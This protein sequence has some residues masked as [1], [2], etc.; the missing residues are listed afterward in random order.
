ME[1]KESSEHLIFILFAACLLLVGLWW[2]TSGRAWGQALPYSAIL[3]SVSVEPDWWATGEL[4]GGQFAYSVSSAGD[5]NGD[6]YADLLVGAPKEELDAYRGGTVHAYYGYAGGVQD[7]P[8]WVLGSE[9]QGSAFGASLGKADLNGDG[10]DEIL[11]GAP[12]F[13]TTTRNSGKVFVYGRAQ[14]NDI[15]SLI[16]ESPSPEP[17]ARYGQSISS[18]DFNNDGY[19]DLLIGAPNYRIV[20]PNDVTKFLTVGAAFV[21]YGSASGL[22]AG[23]V[24]DWT[25]IG[26]QP[27]EIL[28]SSVAGVGDVNGDG[29]DD[30]LVGAPSYNN[31]DLADAGR[32]YLFLGSDSGLGATPA[33]TY[34]GTQ[35][36]SRLGARVSPAGDVNH[37]GHADMLASVR[38]MTG[39][40]T[41]YG[42]ALAFYGSDSGLGTSPSWSFTIEQQN[43]CFGCALASAGDV[44]G[45]QID[46]IIIGDWQYNYLYDSEGQNSIEG[47][48]FIFLGKPSGLSGNIAWLAYGKK[49]EASFGYA[50]ASAGDVNGDGFSDVLIGGPDYKTDRDPVGRADLYLGSEAEAVVYRFQVMLPMVTSR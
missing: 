3:T 19:A 35:A 47:A 11:V 7:N 17:E 21:H 14:L 15:P 49:A 42:Q 4:K 22:L 23:A 50:V 43:T 2:L 5:F 26:T 48:A 45:D 32:M 29:C 27:G 37:D 44:N 24:A 20:D 1:S 34:T 30:L 13:F 40:Y 33:W 39:E 46:D 38:R 12:E 31:G 10:L 41:F 25:Y 8:V 9:Q 16:W 28:G 18:G 6:G 36:N